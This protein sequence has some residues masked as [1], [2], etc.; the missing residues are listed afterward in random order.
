M[1]TLDLSGYLVL[2]WRAGTTRWSGGVWSLRAFHLSLPE[3]LAWQQQPEVGGRSIARLPHPDDPD[4]PAF[5]IGPLPLRLVPAEA[6]GIY[7][8]V[9][10]PQPMVFALLRCDEGESWP[11]PRYLTVSQHEAAR[12]MDGGEWVESCPLPSPLHEPL[13]EF[14]MHH[15]R[16]E[17]KKRVKRNDPLGILGRSTDREEEQ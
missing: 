15:Y 16:P 7:L 5:A 12:W 2:E 1:Q 9:T 8:N 4:A 13:R 17:R 14:A 3:G 6:E 11:T 10:A